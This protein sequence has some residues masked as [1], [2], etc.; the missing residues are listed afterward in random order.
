MIDIGINGAAGRM[1]RR[2]VAL[3]SEDEQ[4]RVVTALERDGHELLGNDAGV[5]ASVDAI[6]TPLAAQ[7]QN[8]PKV[9]IDF[10]VP[11]AFREAL[12]VCRQQ[13]IAMVIGTTGL[14]DDDYK[15]IDAA[16]EDIAILH[17][18]NMSLGVNLLF[19]LVGQVAERLGDDYDIE[20]VE[21]HH[22]FKLDAPSGTA[23]GLAEA[24]CHATGKQIDKDFVHGRHG[25]STRKR[26]EVGMHALRIGDEVGRHSVHFGTLGEEITLAHKA[27]TRDVFARGALRAAAWLADKPVGRYHMKDV[28]GL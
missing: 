12:R 13:K 10:T 18:P 19:A 23:M 15:A 27:S 17:A 14:T 28:L 1:G 2:L 24:I 22:R 5:V 4:L 9:M 16:A 26:G 25:E 11:E 6:N 3:A 21:A 7:V 8:K 20:I